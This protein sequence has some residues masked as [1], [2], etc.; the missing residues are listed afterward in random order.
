MLKNL[1]E[2]VFNSSEKSSVLRY[3]SKF[4]FEIYACFFFF[5]TS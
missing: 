1:Y 2:N 3:G 5:F 4:L